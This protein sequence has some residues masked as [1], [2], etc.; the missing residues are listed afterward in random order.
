MDR[1]DCDVLIGRYMRLLNNKELKIRLLHAKLLII[2]ICC[3]FLCKEETLQRFCNIHVMEYILMQDFYLLDGDYVN[4]STI[5][6][7]K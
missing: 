1:F 6:L 4:F 2:L 3:F 7:N 5:L